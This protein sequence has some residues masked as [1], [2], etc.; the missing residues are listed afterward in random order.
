MPNSINYSVNLG[1]TH[2]KFGL[3]QTRPS[4]AILIADNKASD[5]YLKTIT[6]D[7]NATDAKEVYS[8]RDL[9]DST[10]VLA[11]SVDLLVTDIFN[12]EGEPL[13]YKIKKKR[14]I[15]DKI[16]LDGEE[17]LDVDLHFVYTNQ[18]SGRIQYLND[19]GTVIY[20]EEAEIFPIFIWESMLNLQHIIN[21]DNKTY[22]YTTNSDNDKLII[23]YSKANL[24]IIPNTG[25]IFD[26]LNP[27]Q[28]EFTIKPFILS[29]V[30]EIDGT[31]V[32]FTYDYSR[33]LPNTRTVFKDVG[34]LIDRELVQLSNQNIIIDS[35][36][37][38][39]L[40]KSDL[41][42]DVLY[43]APVDTLE[44]SLTAVGA[45]DTFDLVNL[46]DESVTVTSVTV[47][48]I[49]IPE[50][51][52]AYQYQI[53]VGTGP[54]GEDQLILNTPLLAGEQIIIQYTNLIP[55]MSILQIIY[56]YVNISMLI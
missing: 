26:I 37:L 21:L 20:S 16:L 38:H 10:E 14:D 53:S 12:R 34:R 42:Y 50:G 2:N 5:F 40:S 22:K 27:L 47:D 33:V 15:Y 13:Y 24:N 9:R 19:D 18:Q 54:N 46:E 36:K 1:P 45:E 56:F 43:D 31:R 32:S 44:I 23:T 55:T 48:G 28:Y 8:V 4:D 30:R 39:V 7:V 25:T 11:N 29:D 17:Q 3:R 41:T 6:P 49:D 35:F 51:L 52:N